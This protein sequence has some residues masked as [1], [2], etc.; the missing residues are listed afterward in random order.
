MKYILTTTSIILLL[1]PLLALWFLLFS[2]QPIFYFRI[3]FLTN[4]IHYSKIALTLWFSL[5]F[6]RAWCSMI[7]LIELL[8]CLT[9]VF[10]HWLHFFQCLK[11][12]VFLLCLLIIWL[13]DICWWRKMI[14]TTALVVSFIYFQIFWTVLKTMACRLF[15]ALFFFWIGIFF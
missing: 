6:F 15:F 7:I 1:R 11:K 3:I 12:I 9:K 5:T 2:S 10:S 8:K 14:F 4:I 13:E